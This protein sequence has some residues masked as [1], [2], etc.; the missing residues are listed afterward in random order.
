[1]ASSNLIRKSLEKLELFDFEVRGRNVIS[2]LHY[3]IKKSNYEAFIYLIQ[4]HMCDCLQ[5]NNDQLTPRLTALI[6]SAFYRILL[7]EERIQVLR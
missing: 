4:H 3:V 2:P 6:N 1:M 5:R 7:K